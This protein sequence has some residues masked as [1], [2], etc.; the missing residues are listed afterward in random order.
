MIAR[1]TQQLMDRL[2]DSGY[3][4]CRFVWEGAT[5]GESQQWKLQ[6]AQ[7]RARSR[8][9]NAAN[10]CG[11]KVETHVDHERQLVWA[12]VVSEVNKPDTW[13]HRKDGS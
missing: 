6:G 9:I 5:L 1:Y 12:T 2:I 7:S 3:A 11:F 8:L 4:D 10:R 13:F